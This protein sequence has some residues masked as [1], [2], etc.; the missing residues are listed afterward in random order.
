MRSR[1]P[2]RPPR[3]ARW[4]CCSNENNLLPLDAGEGRPD[5]GGRHPRPRHPDRRLQ[6]RAR[7]TSS[8]CSKACRRQRA[9]ASRSTMPKACASPRQRIWAQD[10]VKLVPAEVNRRLIAEAVETARSADTIV[11]VLG[12][13]EQTSREAWADNHLGD[14]VVARP[15]R[16]AG[17][18]GARDPRARQ[19]DG[20]RAAQR[21]AAVGQLSR[22]RMRRR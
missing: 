3:S 20:G 2:A 1:W 14:R 22:R 18:A 6:R 12:D 8:A 11:M 9:A 13:N 16:P 19:A 4:C 5:G 21:P 7:A 15:D 10:E 17:G